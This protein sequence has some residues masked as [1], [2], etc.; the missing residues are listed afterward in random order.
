MPIPL[1]SDLLQSA[2]YETI[3]S[4]RTTRPANDLDQQVTSV[5]DSRQPKHIMVATEANPVCLRGRRFASEKTYERTKSKKLK[6]R[7]LTPCTAMP[8]QPIIVTLPMP[9]AP[10]LIRYY[11]RQET[12]LRMYRFSASHL[13]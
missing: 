12:T 11:L 4:C 3:T 8:A 2:N 1:S 10:P 6:K 9:F 13:N 5:V 7:G